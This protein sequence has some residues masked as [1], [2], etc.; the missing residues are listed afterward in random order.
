MLALPLRVLAVA[1][2]LLGAAL[3]CGCLQVCYLAQAAAGQD[4]ISYRARPIEEVLKDKSVDAETRQ[5]LSLIEDVKRFGETQGIEPTNSYREYVELDR[6]VVVWVVSAS[7][8]LRFEAVTW[9]FPIV[10]SVPYLGF[11]AERDAKRFAAELREEGW[12]VD[13]RG[14]RAYSTLGW[15]DDPVLST[16][17]RPRQSVVGDM[18]N[19]VIHESVHATHYVGSQSSFNESLADFVAD[20]LTEKYLSERL[21]LDRWELFD[22]RESHVL[23]EEREKRFHRAY[24]DLERVY[25][26]KL[27]DAD[28]LAAKARIIAALEREVDFWRPINNATLIGSRTYHG[29]NRGFGEVLAHCGGSWSRFWKL[30]KTVDESS[31]D[32]PQEADINPLL[33]RLMKGPCPR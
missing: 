12:D 24:K 26:S 19:V 15:F 30:M 28:K 33:K 23:R 11:F 32:K 7:H 5:M 4:D 25:A 17:I 21:A 3:T 10:G 16:M 27:P 6:P 22:Y 31:F 1:L 18:V 14:A 20:Q 13:E 9:W 29:G 8:P 2:A